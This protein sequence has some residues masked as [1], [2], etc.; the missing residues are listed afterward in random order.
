MKDITNKI[1]A[2]RDCSR[3]LWNSYFLNI[4]ISTEEEIAIDN[5][6]EFEAI[7]SILL[8]D[9]ILRHISDVQS[10]SR[11][12]D[13]YYQAI[14]VIPNLGPLG[15]EARF[16]SPAQNYT[17]WEVIQLKADDN[18]FRFMEFFD[19]TITQTM[20]N[21]YVRVRL[22]SSSSL[23]KYIGYDFLLEAWNVVYMAESEGLH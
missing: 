5:L 17:Q 11:N 6:D 8:E 18:D 14:R 9:T 19:W 12:K 10:F 16:A 7:N 4:N 20:E 15:F 1:L 21:Q 2:Y 13:N 22:I 3:H 23:E